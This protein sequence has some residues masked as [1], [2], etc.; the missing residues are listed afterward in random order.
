MLCITGSFTSGGSIA[1][2]TGIICAR[3]AANIPLEDLPKH[4][5]YL[6]DETHHVILKNL[7]IIGLDHCIQRLI[8]TDDNFRMNTEILRETIL[9]D[10]AAGRDF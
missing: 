8:P 7:K 3:D 9:N 4:V 5:V 1:N 2:L 6:T 10:E